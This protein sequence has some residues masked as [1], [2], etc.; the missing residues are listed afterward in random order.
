PP[1]TTPPPSLHDALPILAATPADID[2][3]RFKGDILRNQGKAEAAMFAYR[4]ILARHPNNAQAHI[5]VANLHIDAGKF[6]DARAEIQAA[7]RKS[8]RLNSSHSQTSY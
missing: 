1:S 8:T 2:C 4:S 7:D 6:A 3:L 5:D